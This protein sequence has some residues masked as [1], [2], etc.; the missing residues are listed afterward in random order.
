M[1]AGMRSPRSL[2]AILVFVPAIAAK[3][4]D[5][6]AVLFG[7]LSYRLVGPFRAGRCVTCTGVVGSPDKFYFGAVGGGVWVTENSGRTWTPIFD[8][9]HAASIGAVALAPSDP[10]TIYVGT[11]EADM[12][13]NIQQGEGMYKS[14]DGGRTW[15][16]I[17]LEDTRQ[18]GKVLVDPNSKNTVYVAA[19]GHQYGP[20]KERGVF[21]TTDGGK[22]WT[23]SLY[24]S[25]N[26]GA[27]DLAMDPKDNKTIL[28]SM[29]QT[30][31]PPW[32][33]YPP[34]NGPGSGL[35]KTTDAG[36]HWK[37]V[38]G[39]GLPAFVGHIGLSFASGDRV[40][41]VIDTNTKKGGGVYVSNNRGEN[42]RQTT[43]D[44]RLW[45]RGWYFCKITADPKDPNTVYVMNTA[46]HRSTDGGKT[47]VPI[48][49][50]PGGDD[51]HALWINP[52]DTNRMVVSSDQGTVVSVDRGKTWST[53]LNQPTGQFYHVV[54][55]DRFPY[56]VYG[57]Q[58][59]SGAM[60]V[61]T[62]SSH[63]IIDMH[64]WRPMS[65]GGESGTVAVDRL[66]PGTLIDNGGTIERLEDGWHKTVNPTAGKEGG[67][68]RT[69]WTL[70]IAASPTDPK[71]FYTS[72]Q[73]VFRSSD[74]GDSWKIISPDLTRETNTV[75]PNLDP[76]TAADSEG[77]PR[78][79]VVYWLAPSP[80][81]SGLLWAGTDDGLVWLT[82]DDGAK[83]DNV[84]PPGL[85]PW[86]KVGIIDA[87]HFNAD[88]AY[89]AVD[90]H[91]LDDNAPYVY[92][93]H[94][95][96]RHWAL[97]TTGLPKGEFVNVVREDPFRQGLLYAGTDWG[98][99][100]SFDDG[101]HWQ[102]L[103]LNLPHASV[104]D[105]VFGQNDVVVGTHGR[106]IWIL[107]DASLLRQVSPST[108]SGSPVLFKPADAV[109]FVRG[110]G[111]DDGTP[112]PIEDPRADNPPDGAVIDYFLGRQ[113]ALVELSVTD[114]QGKLVR[115][116]SSTDK[117]APPDV[118][119][120]TVAPF[121]MKSPTPLYT[122][123]G[124]HRFVWGFGGRGGSI[125][126]G[127]YTVTLTVDVT[128]TTQP[129]RLVPDPRDHR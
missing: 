2:V 117:I 36:K 35:Y 89:A 110:P 27:I 109:L 69:T 75:P 84:T 49:G 97:V 121:W 77:G 107:D 66:H 115:K 102:A 112:L 128:S 87:S 99:F 125:A 120:I 118:S 23:K 123:R 10:N 72:H 4:Q 124:G 92:R 8:S 40:Y 56:W 24:L 18:I 98:V 15:L 116:F 42:W 51:Y 29:W 114:S 6:D 58:Q 113:A 126:A 63:D 127:D 80:L 22:T 88:T 48:K 119:R 37:K 30:R 73:C 12:R 70:P 59:D 21:K 74:G 38:S 50:S 3:A 43:G 106:A 53:W 16:H 95:G 55:D 85:T 41:A 60:A 108:A 13:S 44:N 26:I 14:T 52:S 39:H 47:F 33:V 103:Q 122:T 65:V 104:R 67:P 57:A 81:K 54:A 1:L 61:L 5:Y 45:G 83:W 64:E 31:R 34:S 111:F 94:D 25:Q 11:G 9:V 93:T 7:G 90:R 76:T 129:L 100:V 96:G 62:H 105:I 17:G 79:G 46:M 28:A 68:W 101:D 82:R 32:S 20:N 91:R 19:L 78:R 71:V 86:S